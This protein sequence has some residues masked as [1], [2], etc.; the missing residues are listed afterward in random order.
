MERNEFIHFSTS[1]D[2]IRMDI[3]VGL[4]SAGNFSGFD[5]KE[6]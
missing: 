6:F 2:L 1:V 4:M 5:E 3:V